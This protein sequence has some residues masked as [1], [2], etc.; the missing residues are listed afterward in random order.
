[1]IPSALASHVS[2]RARSSAACPSRR[3]SRVVEEHPGQCVA[4]IGGSGEHTGDA[5]DHAAA[6]ATDVGRHGR[7][8]ARP[9][10]R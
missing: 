10:P 2:V 1:M 6:V 3:R 5:V 8:T 7:R 4:E 9:R